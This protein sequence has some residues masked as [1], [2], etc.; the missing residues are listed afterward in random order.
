[1][2]SVMFSFKPDVSPEK[3][4]AILD[5]LE[6]WDS[7]SKASHLKP[8]ANNPA[9]LRMAYAYVEND[10]SAEEVVKKLSAIR[11]ID[12]ASVPAKRKLV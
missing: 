12:E 7:I 10:S 1:M 2:Q 6:H 5:E 3:Q 9:V 4:K 8:D 11:E